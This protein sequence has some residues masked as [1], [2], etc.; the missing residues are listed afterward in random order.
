M[1]DTSVLLADPRA[2]V[3]F[4]EHDV[5]LPIVVLMEL[6]AKRDHPEL[7][8]AAR[9]ALR[10]LE[11]LRLRHGSLTEALPVNGQGGTLRVELNH[12]STEGL[13]ATMKAD[14]NDHRI[15]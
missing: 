6:E 15:L 5:V 7:G 10:H 9:H 3:R 13:P 14:N 12:Q 8:W 1:L 11:E 4:D 2:L